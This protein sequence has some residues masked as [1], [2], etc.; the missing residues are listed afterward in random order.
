MTNSNWVYWCWKQNLKRRT[1][2]SNHSRSYMGSFVPF[3]REGTVCRTELYLTVLS[4][5]LR[6]SHSKNG[7]FG[8]E[9]VWK[10]ASNVE[11]TGG[12]RCCLCW[13]YP[14]PA[15]L[16]GRTRGWSVLLATVGNWTEKCLSRSAVPFLVVPLHSS[17]VRGALSMQEVLFSP[18]LQ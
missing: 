4:E 6:A 14:K 5:M 18:E 15:G 7:W 1:P 2:L 16:A 12:W 3:S 13:W 11:I 9:R 10:L 8:P 17:S